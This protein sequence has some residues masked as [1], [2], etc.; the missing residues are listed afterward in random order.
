LVRRGDGGLR[1]WSGNSKCCRNH[2]ASLWD[3]RDDLP[4]AL[5]WTAGGGKMSRRVRGTGDV[6]IKRIP[7]WPWA[8]IKQ[9]G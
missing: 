3:D 4:R 7:T 8:S 1:P 2:L 9:F 6:G 5:L